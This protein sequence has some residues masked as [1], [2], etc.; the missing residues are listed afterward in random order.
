MKRNWILI[1]VVL[2]TVFTCTL[3]SCSSGN[4]E[5]H[6]PSSGLKIISH[7]VWYGFTKVPERKEAWITWMNQLAPDVVSLQELNEYS[8]QTL[9]EDAQ[10]YGHA[11]SVLLKEEGFPTGITS[12]YPIEDIQRTTE[13]FHHGLL[14][15]RIKGIYMYVIHLH[16][17][18]W[19]FRKNEIRQILANMKGLPSDSKIILA[20]D[21]NTFSPLDS[22]YYAD[23]NLELFF[24]R[25]DSLYGEKNLNQGRLDYS[26]IHDLLNFGLIDSEAVH[27]NSSYVFPGSFPTWIEKEGEHGDI[28]RLDYIFVSRNLVKHVTRAEVL[29]SDSTQILS[30]HLPVMVELD[31]K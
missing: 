1:F 31:V 9:A 25:R 18:N 15:V 14:R 19:E 28:R 6:S 26:V 10:K 22:I 30:D 5:K 13:G 27:R 7:N 3:L 20:G 17:S 23:G 2:I 16:P 24:S 8:P 29:A 11:Y 21:F 4:R 12:R